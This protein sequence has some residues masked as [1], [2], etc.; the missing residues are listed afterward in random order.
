[1]V[2]KFSVKYATTSPDK[3]FGTRTITEKYRMETEV[4]A[5]NFTRK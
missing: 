5:K 4:G 1:M 3:I 2:N